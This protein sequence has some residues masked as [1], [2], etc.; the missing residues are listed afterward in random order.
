MTRTRSDSQSVIKLFQQKFYITYVGHEGVPSTSSSRSG[1]S[2]E[3]YRAPSHT[4]H[5]PNTRVKLR[6]NERSRRFHLCTWYQRGENQRRVIRRREKFPH[7][8]ENLSIGCGTIPRATRERLE[9]SKERRS[10]NGLPGDEI[11]KQFLL[12]QNFI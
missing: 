11:A 5:H 7:E 8:D 9:F 10:P 3:R 12:N 2:P 1:I 6:P 4:K